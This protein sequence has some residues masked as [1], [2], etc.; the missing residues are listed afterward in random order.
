MNQT[1][2]EL[3][4]KRR[5]ASI[6]MTYSCTVACEHCCF[7]CSPGKP[8]AVVSVDN[9]VRYLEEFHKLDRLVH[10]AGGEPFRYPG[11]VLDI[12][13]AA[14]QHGVPPH[15][16]ET[17]CSWCVS[18]EIARERMQ[19]LKANGVRWMLISTDWYHMR[20][21]DPERVARGLAIAEEVFGEGT[22]MGLRTR[23][24]LMEQAAIARDEDELAARIAANP[25]RLVGR[26]AEMY[27]QRLIHTG[28][29]R[30]T[31]GSFWGT[32][33]RCPFQS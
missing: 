14:C 20:Q 32:L 5:Y 17:N 15:F 31:A 3:K 2:E 24:E 26:A 4:K 11:R 6:L 21:L 28:T 18:D 16:V 7:N 12:A 9:A 23:E 33:M 19:E 25:P 13:R 1:I 27:G 10:I 8:E 29:S 22:T 30:R